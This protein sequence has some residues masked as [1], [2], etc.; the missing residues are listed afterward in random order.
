MAS[1]GEDQRRF[2][3]GGERSA[4]RRCDRL[5][6]EASDK[7]V[8]HAPN[9]A[10]APES[11]W[12]GLFLAAGELLMRQPGIVGLHCVTS[13]NALHYAYQTS[14]SDE[15]R[16]ACCCCRPRRSCRCSARPWWA[17]ASCATLSSTAGEGRAEGRRRQAIEEIFADVSKDR[18]L[19]ARKTLGLRG[20]STRADAGADDG[21]PAADLRK[22]RDSHDYKFSSAALED[23]Y[24]VTDAGRPYY[25]AASMFNLHGTGDRDNG[26]IE[27]TKAALARA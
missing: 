2:A 3:G 6:A 11:I 14:A 21:G 1:A 7:V 10:S 12:D 17:A 25:A 26:L 18:T 15:T 9:R 23:Y 20:D 16:A 22:G 4:G 19:A 13:A 8:G 24:N 5:A 27:R